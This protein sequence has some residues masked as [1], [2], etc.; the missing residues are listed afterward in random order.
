MSETQPWPWP[1]SAE[2]DKVIGAYVKACGLMEDVAKDRTANAGSYTYAYADLADAMTEARPKLKDHGLSVSQPPRITD[3]EAEVTTMVLH[4]SGQWI[5][6]PPLAMPAGNTAQSAGSAITYARRYSLLPALGV[7]T[8]DDDGATAGTRSDSQQ[9]SASAG[10]TGN[11]G[12]EGVR[13]VRFINDAKRDHPKAHAR[14]V[15]FAADNKRDLTV[16][17]LAEDSEWRKTVE[18]TLGAFIDGS[19]APEPEQ[20]VLPVD[21]GRVPLGSAAQEPT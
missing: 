1:S 16:R 5:S 3:R 12:N 4:E 15:E 7:A 20:A 21:A 10:A 11:A 2:V 19:P 6:F 17:A 13:V 14:L 8:E 9:A 18:A